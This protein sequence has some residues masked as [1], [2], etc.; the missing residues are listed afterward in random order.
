MAVLL[1][2]IRTEISNLFQT[3]VSA[4]LEPVTG[5]DRDD[6]K[7]AVDA[8]DQWVE[9]NKVAYNNALPLAARTNLTASQK[10]QILTYVVERRYTEGE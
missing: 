3:A 1:D 7:A 6:L 9:D 2:T 5:L 8:A 4:R 10:S